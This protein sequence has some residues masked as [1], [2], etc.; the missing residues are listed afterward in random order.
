MYGVTISPYSPISA[1]ISGLGLGSTAIYMNIAFVLTGVLM[2]IGLIGIFWK[3]DE[4]NQRT[5]WI[6]LILLALTPT[7]AILDGFFTINSGFVHYMISIVAFVVPVVS[8]LVAGL[9]LRKIPRLSRFGS[10]LILGS[11]LTLILIVL[12]FLTFVP[13]PQGQ[14]VG[15]GGLV[16]RILVTEIF[17][18]Y[19]LLGW[20]TVRN[21]FRHGSDRTSAEASRT[22]RHP[23]HPVSSG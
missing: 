18:G 22:P 9:Q 6:A 12:F 8:F 19:A 16:E 21:L 10:W 2:L 3:M 20:I 15:V 1:Q 14:E 11:P 4:E 7:G 13:T 17:L 5:P 23:S